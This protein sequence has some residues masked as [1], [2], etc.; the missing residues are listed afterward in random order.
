MLYTHIFQ[1]MTHATN[2]YMAAAYLAIMLLS[3]LAYILQRVIK[4]Q[5]ECISFGHSKNRSFFSKN[6]LWLNFQTCFRIF[7]SNEKII[8]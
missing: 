7:W 8:V 1:Q 4:S 2:A 6:R 3:H 5:K